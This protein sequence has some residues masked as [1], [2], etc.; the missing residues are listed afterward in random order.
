MRSTTSL[1]LDDGLR[2][3]LAALAEVEGTSVTALVERL[4]HEGLAVAEHPGIVF[5]PGPSGRR[6]AL[7]GGPDVWEIAASLRRARGTEAKRIAAV[8]KEFGIHERQVVIALNYAAAHPDEI[9]VRIRENERA[10]QEAERVA[11]GRKRLLA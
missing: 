2:E 3:R 6:A 5:K 9:D 10:L 4:L 7:A 8:A 11:G 1:R